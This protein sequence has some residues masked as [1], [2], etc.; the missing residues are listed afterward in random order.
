[1][2]LRLFLGLMMATAS[3]ATDLPPKGT[4]PITCPS[5]ALTPSSH[6][7]GQHLRVVVK[8]SNMGDR[9]ITDAVF[10]LGL[11]RTGIDVNTAKASAFPSGRGMQKATLP[12]SIYWLH[13]NIPI[14]RSRKFIFKV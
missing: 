7:F 14:K 13:V 6:N 11:P 5:K 4:A 2:T 10:K 9:D 1:M 12:S 3:L 8:V